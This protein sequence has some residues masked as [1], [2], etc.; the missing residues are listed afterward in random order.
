MLQQK[1][2]SLII[3][4]LPHSLSSSLQLLHSHRTQRSSILHLHAQTMSI[5]N[6][7]AVLAHTATSSKTQARAP[8][9]RCEAVIAPKTSPPPTW[10]AFFLFGLWCLRR[11]HGVITIAFRTF[12]FQHTHNCFHNFPRKFKFQQQKISLYSFSCEDQETAAY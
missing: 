2:T 1:F 3:F 5:E 10:N 11:S 9:V 8:R 12:L 6:A 4:Y 7:P